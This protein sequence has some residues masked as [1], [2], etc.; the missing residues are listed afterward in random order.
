MEDV[1]ISHPE[2]LRAQRIAWVVLAL[3]LTGLGLWTL[4]EFLG[5]LARLPRASQQTKP[6]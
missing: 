4:K 3:T 2:P 1:R 5:A 6:T